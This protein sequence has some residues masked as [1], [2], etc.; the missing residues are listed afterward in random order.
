MNTYAYA[1]K[2]KSV[3]ETVDYVAMSEESYDIAVTLYDGVTENVTVSQEYLDKNT[4]IAYERLI[5]G[6]Y[7]LFYTIDY[8]F[9][10]SSSSSIISPV[11]SD[12]T[13]KEAQD[14]NLDQDEQ[15]S[16]DVLRIYEAIYATLFR[17]E[18][19]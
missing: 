17:D 16:E 4:P 3:Y 7:R 11:S 18:P 8:I 1:V 9:G 12:I 2:D 10:S 15:D 13:T 5:I 6:G 14:S 19:T